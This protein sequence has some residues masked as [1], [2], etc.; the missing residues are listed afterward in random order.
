MPG[1]GGPR[2]QAEP[3]LLEALLSCPQ[4]LLA[5]CSQFKALNCNCGHVIVQLHPLQ[6]LSSNRT[7]LNTLARGPNTPH[8]WPSL[9]QHPTSYLPPLPQLCPF[10]SKVLT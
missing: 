6:G 4:A 7:Q 10:Q 2:R 5:P 3:S 8:G 1:R 9:T